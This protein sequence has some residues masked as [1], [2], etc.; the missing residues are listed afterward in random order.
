MKKWHLLLG[1]ILFGLLA[2]WAA[3][4]QAPTLPP[5]ILSDEQG[6][7]VQLYANSY[8]LL[9]GISNY[10][11][12]WPDL[13]GVSED[14]PAVKAALERHGFQVVQPK[15]APADYA[16]FDRVFR[17]F[18]RDYGSAVENR[19]IFYFAGHG[20]T[21]K[22]Q[23]G[24]D[25]GYLVAAAAPFAEKDR[26]G[27]LDHAL[28]MA[29]IAGYARNIQAKHALFVFDSCFSGSI[30]ENTRG[31]PEQLAYYKASR[32]VRQFITS[33]SKDERV[34]DRSVFREEFV[35]ALE[36][37]GD[38]DHDGYVT[39]GELGNFLD[40]RVVLRRQDEQHPQYGKMS[41]FDK[42]DLVF[43]LPQR[44]TPMPSLQDEPS[45]GDYSIE[46]LKAKAKWNAW[47]NKQM[48]PAFEEAAALEQEDLDAADKREAWARFL[49]NFAQNHPFSEEDDR[50][51]QQAKERIAHW[52][53]YATPTPA[54]KQPTPRPSQEGNRELPLL[55]GA[56]GG[57]V[58][59]A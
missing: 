10:T 16:E 9:I 22:L 48:R 37:D 19:L 14:V 21:L 36:G 35:A 40:K 41:D 34:P 18:I 54:P 15:H 27:F 25:M 26:A 1:V 42:G 38:A 50:M 55:G 20:K 7:R 32:P 45:D 3:A 30:F 5:V 17:E 29:T 52:V 24:R 4:K 57:F 11:N 12:D 44:A 58:L 33:G 8:A 49:Q 23:D 43:Q 56:G 47:L 28:D 6:Q 2:A 46:D 31:E 13:P 59:G 53:N 39:G 51:R